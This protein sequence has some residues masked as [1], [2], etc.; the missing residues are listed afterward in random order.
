MHVMAHLEVSANKWCSLE[1]KN[2][3]IDLPKVLLRLDN[4]WLMTC[5]SLPF[6]TLGIYMNMHKSY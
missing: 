4:Q 2:V 1:W 6:L 5:T 3:I